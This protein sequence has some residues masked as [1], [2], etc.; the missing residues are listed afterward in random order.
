M[1]WRVISAISQKDIKE[2]LK[3]LYVLFALV[4][5][6]GISLLFRIIMPGDVASVGELVIA[7]QQQ[8]P[9]RFVQNLENVENVRLVPAGNGVSLA[10]AITNNNAVGGV[11]VPAGL[12]QT[13]Q[14]GGIR[15]STCI[16]RMA[17]VEERYRSSNP[18][19]EIRLGSLPANK[20]RCG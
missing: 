16:Y 15:K 2:S 12:D 6:I 20:C 18:L 3:N 17:K 10:D 11:V 9:S 19:F 14:A 5:P 7:V 8:E 1:N 13:I 4:M